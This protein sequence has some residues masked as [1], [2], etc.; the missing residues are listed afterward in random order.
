MRPT[1]HILF[2]A[3]YL[4][5]ALVVGAGL[6]LLLPEAG[7]GMRVLAGLTVVIGGGLIH[8]V[9]TRVE[10]DRLWQQTADELLEANRDLAALLRQTRADLAALLPGD[11]GVPA[12]A[13]DGARGSA[14]T[15]ANLRQLLLNRL[16]Q[17]SAGSGSDTSDGRPAAVPNGSQGA[18]PKAAATAA[19]ALPGRST[20]D[21]VLDQVRDAVANDRI[22]VLLQPVVSLPQRKH[23]FYELFS[24]L[25]CRDGLMLP[26]ASFLAEAERRNLIAHIDNFLLM[27]CVLL[28]RET[29][30]HDHSVGF[31]T[32]LSPKSLL[33]GD[34]LEQ[35]FALVKA[36]PALPQKLILEIGQS[37]LMRGET[38]LH[39]LKQLARLGF[40]FSLDQVSSLKIDL[41]RLA[42]HEFRFIKLDCRH[43][44][45]PAERQEISQLRAAMK[46]PPIDL[47]V[48][49]IE[50]EEQLTR[51]MEMNID[52][53]QGYLFGE[54]R[55]SRRLT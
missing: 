40:R 28:I 50:T 16:G 11:R 55:L 30:R 14:E 2:A 13:R 20:D 24:R 42:G 38:T 47:I 8:E 41:P 37:E 46:S 3:G 52:Y 51:L 10:R 9:I 18:G 36:N 19:A 33:D 21:D 54:P 29:E 45:D 15:E 17:T 49:K 26:P 44:L 39:V 32:N 34:F 4:A 6:P 27:R 53:G 12:S 23:R 25:R 22:D 31:F 35:F 48:E 43:L 5:A 1:V 7:Y